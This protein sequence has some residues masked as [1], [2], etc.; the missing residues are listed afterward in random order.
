MLS[1]ADATD[2]HQFMLSGNKLTEYQTA[3][4]ASP[5]RLVIPLAAGKILNSNG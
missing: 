2:G 5:S 1:L 4:D 3:P